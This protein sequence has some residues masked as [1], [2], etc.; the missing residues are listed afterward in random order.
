MNAELR[1]GRKREKIVEGVLELL[2]SKNV[3]ETK[4]KGC[5]NMT[6]LLI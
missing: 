5:D 1:M 3:L 2:V 4:G 6:M